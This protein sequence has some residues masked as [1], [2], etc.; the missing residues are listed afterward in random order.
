M[1]AADYL[2]S[3]LVFACMAAAFCLQSA[4]GDSTTGPTAL[5]SPSPVVA[6]SPTPA[7][8]F[9]LVSVSIKAQGGGSAVSSFQ[10]GQEMVLQGSAETYDSTGKQVSSV[11]VAAWRWANFSDI[12]SN[13]QVFGAVNSS[14]PHAQCDGAGTFVVQ[15]TAQGIDGQDL[16]ISPLFTAVVF[17]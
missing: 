9:T 11:P 16:G 14:H 6:A 17:E 5:P 13:C 3:R 4:C 1:R 10:K 8:F 15:A 12:Q 2:P 7:P